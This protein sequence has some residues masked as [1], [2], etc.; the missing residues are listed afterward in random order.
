MERMARVLTAVQLVEIFQVR[1]PVRIRLEA[2]LG[3]LG[4]SR[5]G[6]VVF[7]HRVLHACSKGYRPKLPSA[8][9]GWRGA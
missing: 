8:S 7:D 3:L 4:P 1:L 2:L 9:L 6:R 5:P